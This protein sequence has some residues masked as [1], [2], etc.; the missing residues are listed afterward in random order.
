MV[1]DGFAVVDAEAAPALA[2]V[3]FEALDGVKEGEGGRGV[4]LWAGSEGRDYWVS[5]QWGFFWL[6]PISYKV[7]SR[8]APQPLFHI[9]LSGVQCPLAED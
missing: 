6:R 8:S 3:G 7:G 5:S 9:P 4:G 2:L 1:G